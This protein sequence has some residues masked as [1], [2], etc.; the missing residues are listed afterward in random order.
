MTLFGIDVSEHQSGLDIYRAVRESGLSFVIIRT[1]DGLHRDLVYRSHVDDARRSTAVLAA[2]IYLRNPNESRPG[3]S[4]SEQVKASLEVMGPDHRLPVWL[5]CETNAGLTPDH[6]REA[7]RLFE[8]AG[9]RV[10]GVYSY[11]P[12]WARHGSNEDFGYRWGAAYPST[13]QRPVQELYPGDSHPQWGLP[14]GGKGVN[15]W[16]YASSG[17]VGGWPY[18]VDVN[19]FRGDINQ[20]R[21]IFYGPEE[22]TPMEIVLPYAKDQ[23]AQDTFYN[24]GPASTQT[25]VRGA[26]GKF[27]TE[28]ELARELGTTTNGTDY[29]GQFPRVLNRHIPGSEYTHRD[30]GAYPNAEAKNVIWSEIVNSIKAGHGVIVNIVAPPSNYPRAV[31]PS[32]QSPAYSGGTVYHY[33]AVMGVS[34]KDGPRKVWVSYRKP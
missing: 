10:I 13:A 12:W 25:V 21:D 28:I 32:T 19:A 26:T 8:E 11:W 34:D 30:V 4:I 15:L 29:I 18:G 2:Y 6:I 31:A 16:Q 9:V 20:L 33:I 22:R 1:N 23:I 7:K 14:F 5:D 27:F 17:L 24:C 3:G